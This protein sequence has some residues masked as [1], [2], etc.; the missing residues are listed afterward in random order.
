MIET[1]LFVWLCILNVD[2]VVIIINIQII[3][4]I[5]SG[6]NDNI[7]QQLMYAVRVE[8]VCLRSYNFAFLNTQTTES[9]N[10]IDPNLILVCLLCFA[11]AFTHSLRCLILCHAILFS[12]LTKSTILNGFDF[13]K[14]SRSR[15]LSVSVRFATPRSKQNRN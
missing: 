2:G 10:K 8:C 4:I 12:A 6:D 14:F 7:S 13:I 15:V 1:I 3:T 5:N 11:R 9:G